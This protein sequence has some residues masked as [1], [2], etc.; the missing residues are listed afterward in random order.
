MTPQK[1]AGALAGSGLRIDAGL[2]FGFLQGKGKAKHAKPLK[3]LMLPP[4]N[5]G[6]E[7]AQLKKQAETSTK[8]ELLRRKKHQ[9]LV[10]RASIDSCKQQPHK[11]N[12]F[13]AGPLDRRVGSRLLGKQPQTTLPM[14][15]TS[16]N[17]PKNI[18][19]KE[20]IQLMKHFEKQQQ[21]Q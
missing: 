21:I 4:E 17:N 10:N 9:Q 7:V 19:S 5:L 12:N 1:T 18:L 14:S 13:M 2:D 15:S 20:Q 6:A 3:S 8:S 11:V 16:A